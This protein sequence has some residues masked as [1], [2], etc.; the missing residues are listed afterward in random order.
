MLRGYHSIIRSLLYLG[1]FFFFFQRVNIINSLTP[2]LFGASQLLCPCR[3]RSCLKF[4][5][6]LLVRVIQYEKCPRTCNIPKQCVYFFMKQQQHLIWK[7]LA[8]NPNQVKATQVSSFPLVSVLVNNENIVVQ[9]TGS[10]IQ[11]GFRSSF[12]PLTLPGTSYIK[13]IQCK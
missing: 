5:A 4:G 10:S 2:S 8:C 9:I 11:H 7:C 3:V 1:I 12:F 13:Q 6:E